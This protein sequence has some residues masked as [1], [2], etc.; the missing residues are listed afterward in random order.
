MNGLELKQY[1]LEQAI[2]FISRNKKGGDETDNNEAVELAKKFYEYLKDE[3]QTAQDENE[4]GCIN[5]KLNTKQCF[6]KLKFTD[7]GTV[8]TQGQCLINRTAS[9]IHNLGISLTIVVDN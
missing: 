8:C 3:I 1:C 7:A 4:G 6:R 2:D 5:E 9:H